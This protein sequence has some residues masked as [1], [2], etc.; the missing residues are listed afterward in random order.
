MTDT[1]SFFELKIDDLNS[2]GQGV[3]TLDKLKVFVDLALPSETIEAELLLQKK[4]YALASLK[5]VKKESPDRVK[6]ICPIFEECGGCQI[7]HLNYEKQLEF[8]TKRVKE[9]L[10]RIAKIEH[11]VPLS[12]LPSPSPLHYRNKIQLPFFKDSTGLSLGLY[13]KHS[14]DIVKVDQCFIHCKRGEEIFKTLSTL[15][16]KSPLPIFDPETQQ[17]FLRHLMIRTGVY[18]DECLVVFITTSKEH[19]DALKVIA[20]EL[21]R[22]HPQVKGVLQNIN[23]KRFNTILGDSYV[24]IQGRA[25]IYEKMND[26]T[27]KISPHAFFQVNPYQAIH[28]YETALKFADLKPNNRL[29][30]AYCGIGMF[31]LLAAKQVHSVLGIE[32]VPSAIEDANENAKLNQIDNVQFKWAI[33]EKVIEKLEDFDVV[34]LNPPRKG[35]EQKVLEV[36]AKRKIS[37]IVY[38]S[39]DPASLARDLAFFKEKGYT[40]QKVQPLDMFP[41]TTHVETVALLT[42]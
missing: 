1:H 26:L 31:S 24:T 13:Q 17:G 34:I 12:C 40:L 35:C 8:K 20:S 39:C 29:L 30:D 15:L 3:G 41:Q 25:Y 9:A 22:A 32:C 11:P 28:L 14:N 7:M 38:V 19:R 36:L 18:T 6:P 2:S 27:F 37:K 23:K 21:M 33:V 42:I 5:K 10:V 4:N 16:K